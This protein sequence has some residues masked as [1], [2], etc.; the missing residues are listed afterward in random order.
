MK[1]KITTK[2]DSTLKDD[3]IHISI[4]TNKVTQINKLI[5]YINLYSKKIKAYKNNEIIELNLNDVIT[6]YSD[7][8]NNYC[9]TKEETYRVKYKLY[10]IENITK[11]F[12]RI[13][14]STIVNINYVKCFDIGTTESVIVKLDDG[15]NE[16]VSRRKI[17]DVMR[18]LD[19]RSI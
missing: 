11:D 1:I 19:E 4:E 13:S 8:K 2:E 17:K 6:F 16:F 10:E 18:Y 7:K 5:E 14:K 15:T 9:R 12:I 3:E